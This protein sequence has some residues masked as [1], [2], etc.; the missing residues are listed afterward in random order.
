MLVLA[1]VAAVLL[2]LGLSLVRDSV[3]SGTWYPG[4]AG[5]L[6]REVDAFMD[7]A[8]IPNDLG[9]P[10][11]IIVPHAGYSYSGRCA[12]FG[13]AA[14]RG[15]DYRRVVLIGPSHRMAISGAAV[16]QHD[17]WETPLGEVPLDGAAC[18]TLVAAG[19]PLTGNND[20]HQ[21]EHSLEIQLPF[22]QRA[23]GQFELVPLVLQGVR[24]K[25]ARAIAQALD[26]I[27]DEQTLVVVSSDFTHY[28][29]SFG[30]L[31][32]SENIPENLKE[33][34]MGAVETIASGDVD[35]F[36][37]Y[38][39]RTGATICGREPITVL[40]CLDNLQQFGRPQ[41]LNYTTSGQT[42]GDWSHVVSYVSMGYVK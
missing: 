38:C 36:V 10:R 7:D 24:L 29:S 9:T 13:Y 40:M 32:F 6:Q 30:Y 8:D 17:A 22:L 35:E 34:D 26:E 23:L 1:I 31:P 41:L 19:G 21:L 16:G 42:T 18:R 28:G 15:A 39:D 4:T 25:Q 27:V 20:P 3:I 12:G 11:A 5:A 2:V 33:L 14:V 37:N